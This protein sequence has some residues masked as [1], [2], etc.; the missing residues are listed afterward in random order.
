MIMHETGAGEPTELLSIGEPLHRFATQAL[1]S[2]TATHC[3]T[4]IAGTRR[5]SHSGNNFAELYVVCS[6]KV[7]Y[8]FYR[9]ILATLVRE[10]HNNSVVLMDH[11]HFMPTTYPGCVVHALSL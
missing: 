9:R 5:M 4:P 11:P 10:E 8:P 6:T 1:P 7:K 2:R 3:T